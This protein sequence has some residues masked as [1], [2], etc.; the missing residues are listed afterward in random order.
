MHAQAKAEAASSDR[1]QSLGPGFT[2]L[3]AEI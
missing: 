2:V 3:G 1:D